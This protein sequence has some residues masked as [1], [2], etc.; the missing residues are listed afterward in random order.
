MCE[1]AHRYTV[2]VIGGRP[3]YVGTDEDEAVSALLTIDPDY[4]EE[5]YV[6]AEH[7]TGC[8]TTYC[9]DESNRIEGEAI[10]A[11]AAIQAKWQAAVDTFHGDGPYALAHQAF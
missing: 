5:G 11:A 10:A 7:V 9:P 8:A 3:R 2:E 4:G 1:K 6:V